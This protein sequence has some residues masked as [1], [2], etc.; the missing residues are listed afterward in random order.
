MLANRRVQLLIAL[1]YLLWLRLSRIFKRQGTLVTLCYHEVTA[2]QKARFLAQMDMLQKLAKP[3]FADVP[4]PL[5]QGHH[6]A[7]TFDDGFQN[8]LDNALPELAQRGIPVTL[9]IPSGY[10]ARTPAWLQK[11]PEHEAHHLLI[12]SEQQLRNLPPEHVHVGSHSVHHAHLPE[13]DAHALYSELNDSKQQ[14]ETMLG[15]P[16]NLLAFPY[17]EWNPAVLRAAQQAGYKRV[18]A[19]DPEHHSDDFFHD[20]VT[21]TP[22]DGLLEFK[23]KMLG[24]YHWLPAADAVVQ[25]IKKASR[26]RV[27]NNKKH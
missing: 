9:F 3:V 17:G 5:P 2:Q 25:T 16:I 4:L 11:Y 7:V 14:L 24:A 22:D 18:F 21:L 10:L 1:L 23:L 20:R 12:M 8:L 19:A 13:L 27:A 26:W 6:V 15:T